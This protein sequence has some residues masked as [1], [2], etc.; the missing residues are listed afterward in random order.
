MPNNVVVAVNEPLV[1]IPTMTKVVRELVIGE[2]EIACFRGPAGIGKTFGIRQ[3]AELA[4][5]FMLETRFGQFDSVDLRGMPAI[6]ALH[7]TTCWYAPACMPFEGVPGFPTDRPIL[8]F[9]D[10]ITSAT[11][12]VAAVLYQLLQDRRVGEHKVMDNVRICAAG[13]NETDRGVVYRT[14]A[15]LDNRMFHFQVGVDVKAW[16]QHAA[17]AGIAPAEFI[18]YHS[19]KKTALLKWDPEAADIPHTVPTPRTWEKAAKAFMRY[20]NTDRDFARLLMAAAIG[21]GETTEL[22]AFLQIWQRVLKIEDIIAAPTRV[23]L[24][25]EPSLVY[26]TAISVSSHMDVSNVKALHRFLRRL[27]PEFCVMAWTLAVARNPAL[28]G[29]DEFLEM[30]DEL[31]D[32]FD[33]KA[34]RKA[35]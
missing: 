5:A 29:C 23:A 14:P 13:N 22:C 35:A 20:W 1:N 12:S 8:W 25:D 10:E 16:C 26:A 17:R 11:P 18:A 32:I 34:P 2:N 19:W 31:N 21:E 9:A 30:G 15:P 33:A 6:D 28:Y 4:G 24:P 3:A 27:E 7:N